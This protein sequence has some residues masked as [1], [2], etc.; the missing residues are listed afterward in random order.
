M[1]GYERGFLTK[2]A[3]AGLPLAMAVSL[4]KAAA[5]H[6]V[7]NGE[8]L[9]RIA[10]RYGVSPAEIA[11][12]N[13]IA[14]PNMIRAGQRL[15]IPAKPVAKPAAKPVAKPVAKPAPAPV[16]AP[17]VHAP[18]TPVAAPAAPVQ[19]PA[20]PAERLHT[21]A[22]GE[23]LGR[24]ARQYGLSSDAIAKANGIANPN[25]IRVG[26]KLRIPAVAAAPAV[27]AV[28]VPASPAAKPAAKPAGKAPIG[29]RQN[30][31]G[32]LRS[33]GKTRWYGGNLPAK[34]KFITFDT[35]EN[36]IRAMA[37]ILRNYEL[38]KRIGNLGTAIRTYA[39][40]KE[41]DVPGYIRHVS[42]ATGIQPDAPIHLS[43]PATL[44]TLIPAMLSKEVGP[45]HSV[46]YTP[47]MISNAVERAGVS[48]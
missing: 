48:L 1:T 23:V 3:E 43:D 47:E 12:A 22:N 14:N 24:I 32:N 38:K 11:K 33:D 6:V 31:P 35:P 2:C 5:D 29:V 39:P 41:N 4:M 37:R 34:G 8:V 27:P 21:V 28:P 16:Q 45:K 9:G 7:A 18:A 20:Q 19:A 46:Q 40:A 17:P 36:G 10:K 15:V 30:N 26:Q 44:R 25:R 42:G 13:G